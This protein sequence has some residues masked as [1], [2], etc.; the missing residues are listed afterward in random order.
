MQTKQPNANPKRY[1]PVFL[2][3]CSSIARSMLHFTRCVSC[4]ATSCRML[5]E[6]C[7]EPIHMCT[8]SIFYHQSYHHPCYHIVI[9]SC[10][11]PQSRVSSAVERNLCSPRVESFKGI[12]MFRI[13][14]VK[15]IGPYDSLSP[16]QS[17]H[18]YHHPSPAHKRVDF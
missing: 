12:V 18:P 13:H 3:S 6:C 7:V 16:H 1:A 8:S 11:P 10:I 14:E 17:Q 5:Q 9:P 15:V 4:Y 2:C